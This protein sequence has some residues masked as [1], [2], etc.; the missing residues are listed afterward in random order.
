MFVTARAPAS[1]QTPSSPTPQPQHTLHDGGQTCPVGG[2]T[3]RCEESKVGGGGVCFTSR[4]Q[5]GCAS[6]RAAQHGHCCQWS[7]G[8]RTVLGNKAFVESPKQATIPCHELLLLPTKLR[9]VG[10]RLCLPHWGGLRQFSPAR[11]L[12]LALCKDGLLGNMVL[13]FH[14]CDHHLRNGRVPFLDHADALLPTCP[15]CAS[16]GTLCARHPHTSCRKGQR[17]N[18]PCQ[19]CCL[20]TPRSWRTANESVRSG[21]TALNQK[22]ALVEPHINKSSHATCGS[23]NHGIL[24]KEI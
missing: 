5:N 24:W 4:D 9:L 20:V 23:F 22:F 14:R 10:L 19:G 7:S 16:P 17:G 15:V 3:G 11:M 8:Q 12:R 18:H 1:R 6:I 13:S 21:R 2:H